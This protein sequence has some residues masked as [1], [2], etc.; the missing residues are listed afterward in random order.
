VFRVI[1][2]K[3]IYTNHLRYGVT[4]MGIGVV[5]LILL[6]MILIA[7]VVASIVAIFLLARRR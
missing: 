4:E 6:T 5:E 3:S 2:G 1:S 7:I